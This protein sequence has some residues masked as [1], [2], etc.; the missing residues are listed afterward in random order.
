MARNPSRVNDPGPA[1]A[2]VIILMEIVRR[3]EDCTQLLWDNVE[4]EHPRDSLNI[5]GQPLLSKDSLL[6]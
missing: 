3:K 4:R 2:D 5:S 6:L 1:L